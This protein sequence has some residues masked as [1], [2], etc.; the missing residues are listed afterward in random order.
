MVVVKGVGCDA[1]NSRSV[2]ENEVEPRRPQNGFIRFSCRLRKF[3]S[4]QHPNLDNREISRMLGAKWRRMTWEEKKPFSDEFFEEM[5]QRRQ[6]FPEWNYAGNRKKYSDVNIETEPLPN[7]LRSRSKIRPPANIIQDSVC[8]TE[9]RRPKRRSVKESRPQVEKHQWVQCD[10][11]DKWRKLPIMLCADALPE[12][13]YCYMNPDVNYNDC[14]IPETYWS[15]DVDV[16]I[17]PENQNGVNLQDV[18]PGSRHGESYSL[19]EGRDSPACS[20]A[21]ALQNT[22]ANFFTSS[23][24]LASA[25]QDGPQTNGMQYLPVTTFPGA[26]VSTFETGNGYFG[27]AN[28]KIAG[29]DLSFTTASGNP[30]TGHNHIPA[31]DFQIFPKD[32]DNDVDKLTIGSVYVTEADVGIFV[33]TSTMKTPPPKE[34]QLNVSRSGSETSSETSFESSENSDSDSDKNHRTPWTLI[35]SLKDGHE[36]AMPGSDLNDSTDT[37][38]HDN[39]ITVPT[40]DTMESETDDSEADHEISSIYSQVWSKH[41]EELKYWVLNGS[42]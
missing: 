24:H 19:A 6:E 16:R 10:R 18:F 38:C 31:T 27:S 14:I 7:R 20:T 34:G 26:D 12:Q 11:C 22:L 4:E 17:S 2:K 9:E 32:I 36:G 3:I 1:I 41:R 25:R 33:Q 30:A 21:I 29:N 23:S 8:I 15:E 40:S 28:G 13:W 39:T 37:G 42:Q 5:K 35:K